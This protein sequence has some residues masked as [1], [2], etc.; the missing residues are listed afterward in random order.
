MALSSMELVK[1]A[2]RTLLSNP[3]LTHRFIVV[4]MPKIKG[5]PVPN[6]LDIAFQRVS[7]LRTGVEMESLGQNGYVGQYHNLPK[8]YEKGQLIF[9]R[10]IPLASPLVQNLRNA[11]NNFQ[12]RLFDIVILLLGE[13]HVPRAGWKVKDAI[14]VQW[15]MSDL[16]AEQNAV[17]IETIEFKYA[18]L[19]HIRI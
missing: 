13:T 9:E 8:N 7:G 4:F 19:K 16:N 12:F 10:G 6:P 15:Q 18:Q 14:P 5:V 1:N 11:M 2:A 3:P 17:A